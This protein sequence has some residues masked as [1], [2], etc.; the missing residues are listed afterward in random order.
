MNF[1]ESIGLKLRRAYM[2]FLRRAQA[3]LSPHDVT[4]DQFVM[5][6][7]LAEKDGVTQSSLVDAMGS[8]SSTVADMV[9]RLLK[10]D[11][12]VIRKVRSSTDGRAFQVYLTEEGRSLHEELAALVQ[13]IRDELDASVPLAFQEDMGKILD[14]IADRMD[15]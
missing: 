14:D 3:V 11:V 8:D 10:H 7:L 1:Q 9:K 6:S 5:L 4:A 15:P 13:P 12:Q 2:R